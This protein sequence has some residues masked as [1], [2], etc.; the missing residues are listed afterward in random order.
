MAS[1]PGMSESEGAMETTA[2]ESS[3]RVS[4]ACDHPVCVQQPAVVNETNA[5]I[6][7]AGPR[8]ELLT[9]AIL[10]M[11][12]APRAEWLRNVSS[13]PAQSSTPISLHTTLRV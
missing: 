8:V 7:H 3:L 11:L 12:P 2:D 4:E 13:P 5:A 6:G 1:M 10:M 9:F